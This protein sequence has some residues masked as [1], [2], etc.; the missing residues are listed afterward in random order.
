M[1]LRK[2]VLSIA[3][4]AASVA[5]GCSSQKAS[6][7][8]EDESATRQPATEQKAP[9]GLDKPK[10]IILLIGDGMGVPAVSA[11]SYAH[12]EPLAM[13]GMEKMNWMTTHS[14]EFVTTDSAASAS[15]IAT[16]KKNHYEGVSVKPGTTKQNEEDKKQHLKTVLEKAEESGWRTGL[17]STSKIV[18]ATPAAFAAHRAN[19]RSYDAIARDMY[20]SGVDVLLGGGPRYFSKRA[21]G[22]DLLAA[23]EKKGYKVAQTKEEIQQASELTTKLI[24]LPHDPDFPPAGDPNR[25]MTL[26]EMTQSAL[27][28]LD[29]D[30]D[31]GFFLMVEGSQIDWRGHDLDGEGVVKE[32]LDFDGAVKAAL[33]YARERDDTLV[34]VTS[35]HET[36]GLA[37][38]DPPY[39]DRFSGALGGSEKAE[40]LVSFPKE[41]GEQEV[42]K[43]AAEIALG[44]DGKTKTFGPAYAES[45]YM[46]TV[47][48]HLSLASRSQCASAR[49]FTGLHTPSLVPVFT[50]GKAAEYVA[51]SEDNAELGQRLLKLVGSEFV[52]A[53][54]PV[55]PANPKR[56]AQK[57][58]N[59]IIMVGD[60]M[61]IGALTAAE[62]GRGSLAM[63]K[64]PVEG[65]V[66]TH[67]ADRLVSDSAAGA[68]ALATGKRTNSGAVGMARNA[69]GLV[70]AQTLI[71][72]AEAKGMATGLVTT[73]T[74]THATPAAFFAHQADRGEESKIADQFVD[75]PTRVAGS[76]GVDVAFGAGA[77]IFGEARIA[78]LEE[79]GVVVES[80]WSDTLPKGKQ[81]VRF[82]GEKGMAPAS[83]R[84]N[85]EDASTPTLRQMTRAAINQLSQSNNGF[86]LVVEGGQ[87]DWAQ[88]GLARDKSLIDEVAD[89]DDAVA[90][91]HAF[92]RRDGNT[93]L[94]VTADHDHTTSVIDDHYQFDN[95]SCAAAV[96]CGG[97]FELEKIEAA[98]DKVGFNEG[99]TDTTLQGKY[100]PLEISIQYAWLVQEGAKR[101]GRPG[102]HS[103]NFVPLFAYG[104]QSDAFG[105]FNDI[106]DIGALLQ[107]ALR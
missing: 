69:E 106:P 50:Q 60:G 31:D 1:K 84:M 14:Y 89:F 8:S 41:A 34:V 29:R 35:D 15:A 83:E 53:P 52:A 10:R 80:A 107:Q 104:P 32:T 11:A 12:G 93:L 92:A 77:Q 65:L 48:G 33:D 37:V 27:A 2:Y 103:A 101:A 90:E 17:V 64:L 43:L 26:A 74:L 19:R 105:G 16:G 96:E 99:L 42:P 13:L 98:V 28:V 36:G 44:R 20:A 9:E 56:A 87:I 58:Q 54:N 67:A 75:L 82:L 72:Q 86:V 85:D 94:V 61:G 88:H 51:E 40:G 22:E 18:H 24:G 63:R 100:S 81:V 57:P 55:G 76:D 39:T 97:D 71:E 25:A 73:T 91:A 30:N 47:F 4:L 62:Y 49:E 38:L 7:P 21:D 102:P 66:S 46:N 3:L 59:I 95:C 23:F 70:S 6:S 5:A 78:K 45:G 68:T 79:R